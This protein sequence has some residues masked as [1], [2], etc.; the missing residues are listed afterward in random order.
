MGRLLSLSTQYSV[1]GSVLSTQ[2]S[3]LRLGREVP[4]LDVPGL[5]GEG[6]R[7]AEVQQPRAGGGGDG[8][9]HQ[10]QDGQVGLPDA[11]GLVH[12]DAPK[13]WVEA[14]L[15]LVQQLVVAR[16]LVA[17]VVATAVAVSLRGD[18]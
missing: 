2:Y 18:V 13:A 4:L 17:A 15:E 7:G 6:G 10:R 5:A 16:I 12:G 3:A 14:A 1:L 8:A 11:L 9:Q